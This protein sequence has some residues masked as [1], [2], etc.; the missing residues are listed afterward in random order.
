M[1]FRYVEPVISV[2]VFPG[3]FRVGSH[4]VEQPDRVGVNAGLAGLFSQF[5]V[6]FYKRAFFLIYS[7]MSG[8]DKK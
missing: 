7:T 5:V 6:V 8:S 3:T 4:D 2:E 1:V